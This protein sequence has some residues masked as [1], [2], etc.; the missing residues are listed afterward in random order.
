MI[1]VPNEQLAF[2]VRDY[3]KG[4]GIDCHIVN[5]NDGLYIDFFSEEDRK[6]GQ[7]LISILFSQPDAL[8]K[9]SNDIW[10]NNNVIEFPKVK[11]VS[12]KKIMNNHI[13]TSP[14]MI[15]II[16]SFIVYILQLFIGND[17]VNMM[18]FSSN[19]ISKGEIWRIITPI[20]LHFSIFHIGFNMVILYHFGTLVCKYF[21]NSKFLY[22][23]FFSAI[24]SNIAQYYLNGLNGAFG[25][26]SGVCCALISYV[27]L[28]SFNKRSPS[29]FY[30]G[31]WMFIL[32]VI[33]M[34]ISSITMDNIAN[35]AHVFGLIVGAFIGL[36]D[37][38]RVFR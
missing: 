25:G 37:Y 26:M 14:I 11:R 34:M 38:N 10:T 8:E 4:N 23:M 29:I 5:S 7:E 36:I 22:L 21:S 24:I 17:F 31:R 2:Y 13:W 18:T 16:I 6:K 35:T 3:I 28:L 1:K 19:S 33:F 15:T 30:I 27:G 12:L 9:L 20:F 32:T